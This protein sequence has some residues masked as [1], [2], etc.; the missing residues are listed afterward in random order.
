MT[1]LFPIE[2]QR[3]SELTSAKIDRLQ[4]LEIQH[5][6]ENRERAATILRNS[7]TGIWWWKKPVLGPDE[8]PTDEQIDEMPWYYYDNLHSTESIK[9][10]YS[11]A[12]ERANK[13]RNPLSDI[14]RLG[15]MVLLSTKDYNF[16]IED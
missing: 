13:L 8:L 9:R 14:Q 2:P 1:S 16:L 10:L 4:E 12:R 3:L 5:L 15:Q 7:Y 6:D 11:T